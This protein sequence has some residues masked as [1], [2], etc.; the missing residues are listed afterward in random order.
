MFYIFII[1]AL[2]FYAISLKF[3]CIFKIVKKA[4]KLT[5]A[6]KVGLLSVWQLTCKITKEMEFPLGHQVIH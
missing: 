1:F 6:L 2:H 3:L 4:L 5:A